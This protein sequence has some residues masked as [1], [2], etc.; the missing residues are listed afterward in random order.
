LRS[1]GTSAMRASGFRAS[2]Q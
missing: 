2:P 1:P